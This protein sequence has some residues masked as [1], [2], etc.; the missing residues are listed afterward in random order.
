MSP[1]KEVL[2]GIIQH[3]QRLDR[4]VRKEEPVVPEGTHRKGCIQG[5]KKEPYM[6]YEVIGQTEGTTGQKEEQI[7]GL[8]REKKK[9]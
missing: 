9:S 7:M 2:Q 4:V 1:S 5:S 6:G 8:V 3:V